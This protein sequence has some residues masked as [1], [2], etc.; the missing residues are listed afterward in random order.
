VPAR[1]RLTGTGASLSP[2]ATPAVVYVPAGDRGLSVR[3]L[4]AFPNAEAATAALP[5]LNG[6]RLGTNIIYAETVRHSE[7]DAGPLAAMLSVAHSSLLLHLICPQ[8]YRTDLRP[9]AELAAYNIFPGK[10]VLLSNVHRRHL[11]SNLPA[12]LRPF[13]LESSCRP[14]FLLQ[15]KQ[16]AKRARL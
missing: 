16:Y 15:A 5:L 12:V 10:T 11:Q 8:L 4:V 3:W 2:C 13:R 7:S 1:G 6:V 9:A 14:L